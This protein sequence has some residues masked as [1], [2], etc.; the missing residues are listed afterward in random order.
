MYV[1]KKL[2]VCWGLFD[3]ISPAF[4]LRNSGV[5]AVARSFQLSIYHRLDVKRASSSVPGMSAGH[6][7]PLTCLC[8]AP[9]SSLYLSKTALSALASASLPVPNNHRFS[10]F[11]SLSLPQ[12]AFAALANLP[13][14]VLALQKPSLAGKT[15]PSP[16]LKP[17][18]P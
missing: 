3:K 4:E 12:T 10:F 5:P 18:T 6:C 8:V 13:S 11:S 9:I 1:E 14:E 15:F 16:K 2:G 17:A 7:V